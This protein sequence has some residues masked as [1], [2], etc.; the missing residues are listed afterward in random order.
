MVRTPRL[1]AKLRKRVHMGVFG[2]GN[3]RLTMDPEPSGLACVA[4]VG[5]S[6]S[7]CA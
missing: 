1:R 2:F 4:L 3:L 5:Y 7:R 6:L